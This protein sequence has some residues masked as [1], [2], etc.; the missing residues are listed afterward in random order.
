[1][2][3]FNDPV[4]GYGDPQYSQGQLAG[5]LTG[6]QNGGGMLGRQP[7]PSSF[8][9]FGQP[10][11]GRP[12][13]LPALGLA[14]SAA[15]AG[16]RDPQLGLS[17]AANN[18]QYARQKTLYD[19]K[20]LALNAWLKAKSSG[21]AGALDKATQ[22]LYIADPNIAESVVSAQ[23]T[24]HPSQ[25]TY[26][27][28][29]GAAGT[30]EPYSGVYTPQPSASAGGG[31]ANGVFPPGFIFGGAKPYTDAASNETGLIDVN[32]VKAVIGKANPSPDQANAAAAAQIAT[33]ANATIKKLQTS[34]T[35]AIANSITEA[36]KIPVLGPLISSARPEGR[37]YEAAKLQ[38]QQAIRGLAAAKGLNP[39]SAEFQEPALFPQ[40]GASKEEIAQKDAYRQRI[41]DGLQTRAGPFAQQQGGGQPQPQSAPPQSGGNMPTISDPADAMK[42]PPGTHFLTPDGREKVRP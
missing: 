22:N 19:A 26:N 41:I 32:G 5:I 10:D 3:N 31:S 2:A 17:E 37:R 20:R 11:P 1:M 35:G 42:L 18:A 23:M 4:Y 36:G 29:T 34:E 40:Q 38:F 25:L 24:P 14:L 33:D 28:V 15:I 9:P 13:L 21:D 27:P 8:V 12:P 7:Q 6:M 16:G 30:F 39:D